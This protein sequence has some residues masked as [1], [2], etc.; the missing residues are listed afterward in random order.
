MAA[1]RTPPSLVPQAGP[2]RFATVE[3]QAIAPLS[4]GRMLDDD[5]D[6]DIDADGVPGFA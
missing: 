1:V 5:F 2:R 3:M 4:T 6:F